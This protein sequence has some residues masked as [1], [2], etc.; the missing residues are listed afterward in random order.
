MAQAITRRKFAAAV[1][2][3]SLAA[4]AFGRR[5]AAADRGTLRFIVRNDL[6]VVDPMWTTAYVTRNHTRRSS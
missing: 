3:A 5:S 6:R 2:T 4:F 1:S